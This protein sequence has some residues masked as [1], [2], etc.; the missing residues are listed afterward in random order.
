MPS[1]GRRTKA[2]TLLDNFVASRNAE[3]EAEVYS[4]KKATTV[5]HN[6][7]GLLRDNCI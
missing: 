5:M 2:L 3:K 7:C 1:G 6:S 4:H